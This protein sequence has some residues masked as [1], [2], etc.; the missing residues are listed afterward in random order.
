MEHARECQTKMLT[1]N[2]VYRPINSVFATVIPN[3]FL[4]TEMTWQS[5]S[6]AILNKTGLFSQKDRDHFP[7]QRVINRR[8]WLNNNNPLIVKF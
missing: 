4:T 3:W 6:N 5:F 2:K 8:S 7:T 1:I